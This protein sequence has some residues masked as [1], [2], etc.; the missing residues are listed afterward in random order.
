MQ[1]QTSKSVAVFLR[2]FNVPGFSETLPAGDYEL[3]TELTAPTNHLDPAEWKASVVMRL[4]PRR[5]YPGLARALTVSLADLDHARVK[6]KLTGKE[7][8]EFFVD[9]MLADPMTRLVMQADGVTESQIRHLY[10]GTTR[11]DPEGQF[12]SRPT[13]RA[14]PQASH[15]SAQIQAAENEGMPALIE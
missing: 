15:D 13:K 5:N 3:E 14:K 11:S 8:T 6:D 4:H 12:A 1:G 7:L 10:L 2:P 9:E